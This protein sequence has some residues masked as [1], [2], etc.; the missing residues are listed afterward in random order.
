MNDS[1][2]LGHMFMHVPYSK[3]RNI[4]TLSL[5]WFVSEV[6]L[7]L[8]HTQVEWRLGVQ[9]YEHNLFL[10]DAR[11][12]N[13]NHYLLDAVSKIFQSTYWFP[14]L[15]GVNFVL[16]D[17]AG[18]FITMEAR[19]LWGSGSCQSPYWA[20]VDSGY[21]PLQLVS[22]ILMATAVKI[23]YFERVFFE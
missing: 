20:G 12:S 7:S 13:V 4:F 10:F 18:C 1:D 21:R 3:A 8:N 15:W 17:L 14:I 5:A 2:S 23:H 19:R 6:N 11:A 16:L 9:R 22:E